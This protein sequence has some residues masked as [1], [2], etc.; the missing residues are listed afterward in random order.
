MTDIS[1]LDQV[2]AQLEIRNAIGALA[3]IT[4]EGDFADYEALLT[5][6]VEFDMMGR[7]V[8]GPAAVL[9]GMAQR[10][11]AGS[12]GPGS[13]TRHCV[14]T[15]EVN[16]SSDST[17]ESHAAWLLVADTLGA[18]TV[19]VLGTYSD[20]WVKTPTGWKLAERV[21]KLG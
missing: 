12:T 6:D 2:A 13:N 18:K 1:Q 20:R 9:E 10:R 17:A 8:L 14:T 11:A 21:V 15:V 3:R 19:A 4:D 5:A 7:P 16:L